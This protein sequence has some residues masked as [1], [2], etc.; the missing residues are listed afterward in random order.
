MITKG[1]CLLKLIRNRGDSMKT[2]EYC[3]IIHQSSP[4]LRFCERFDESSDKWNLKKH[5]HPYIELIYYMEGK[6][7]L[8]AGR[9]HIDASIFDTIASPAARTGWYAAGA[10]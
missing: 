9:L 5:S 3:E 7:G 8:E 4:V 2:D 6:A 1:R 10:L